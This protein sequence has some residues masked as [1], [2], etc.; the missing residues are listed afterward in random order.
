MA[1]AVKLRF[2]LQVREHAAGV[3]ANLMKGGDEELSKAFRERSYAEAEKILTKRK[4][5]FLQLL[6]SILNYNFVSMYTLFW[7]QVKYD[8]I[9]FEYI[10]YR[11]SASSL[12]IVTVHGAVLALTAS[13]LSAPYDMPGY[14]LLYI[15]FFHF[16]LPHCPPVPW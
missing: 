7:K 15:I 5:R 13:V 3:L 4:Q 8:N 14:C 11:K 2:K 16:I 1:F 12:S 6:S 10:L 9:R